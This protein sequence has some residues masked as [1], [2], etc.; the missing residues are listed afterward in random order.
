MRIIILL[1]IREKTE[2]IIFGSRLDSCTSPVV[3]HDG[4]I[5]QVK[6]NKYLGVMVDNML[7]WK[8]H[9]DTLC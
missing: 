8:D 4:K 6:I 7:S 5:R 1:L 9:I 2:E 3:T